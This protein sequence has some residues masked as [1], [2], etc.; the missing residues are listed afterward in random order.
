MCVGTLDW[1]AGLSTRCTGSAPAGGP[2]TSSSH[3]TRELARNSSSTD[4]EKQAG[5]AEALM[6][7]AERPVLRMGS[8]AHLLSPAQSTHFLFHL[9][10]QR[11][12]PPPAL[13][14]QISLSYPETLSKSL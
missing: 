1:A 11:A 4:Q 8:R 14:S 12:S 6:R 7:K 5:R 10:I 13:Q 2:Q 9:S 3:I